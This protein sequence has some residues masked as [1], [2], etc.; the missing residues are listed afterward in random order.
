MDFPQCCQGA[1][2]AFKRL[3][4]LLA[5]NELE[6]KFMDCSDHPLNPSDD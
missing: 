1:I 2:L 4:E 3:Q 5:E 6:G